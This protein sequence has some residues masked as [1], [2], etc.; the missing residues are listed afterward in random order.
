MASMYLKYPSA[1]HAGRD[2]QG[3][4]D[5][6]WGRQEVANLHAALHATSPP[7]MLTGCINERC[8]PVH[9]VDLQCHR[10]SRMQ[11]ESK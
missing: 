4:R 1:G 7:L 5:W 3:L 2:V 11:D 8:R 9:I 10:S 6:S